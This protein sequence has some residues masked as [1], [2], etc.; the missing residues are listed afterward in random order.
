MNRDRPFLT[1][2]DQSIPP[3]TVLPSPWV[4]SMEGVWLNDF[5]AMFWNAVPLGDN[6]INHGD[7]QG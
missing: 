1:L 7:F 2:E 6:V 5:Q 4:E 3:D